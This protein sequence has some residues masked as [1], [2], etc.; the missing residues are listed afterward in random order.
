MGMGQ[1]PVIHMQVRAKGGR[2]LA[3]S[4]YGCSMGDRVS[5]LFGLGETRRGGVILGQGPVQGIVFVI[6][7]CQGRLIGLDGQ[8]RR[9]GSS[10]SRHMDARILPIAVITEAKLDGSSVP[11]GVSIKVLRLSTE[12]L[13]NSI[14]SC[15][16]GLDLRGLTAA[17]TAA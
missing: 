6:A 15:R 4:F 10:F 8:P 14:S 13:S 1:G 16:W 12:S 5:V 17:T 3:I 9:A 2:C 7:F 11:G